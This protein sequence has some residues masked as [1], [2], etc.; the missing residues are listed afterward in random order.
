ML[1][2]IRIASF[3]LLV[4]S[5]FTVAHASPASRRE[6][7]NAERLARG[8]TPARPRRL[9]NGSRTNVARSAPSNLPGVVY[10]GK[11]GV[12][13]SGTSPLRKRIDTLGY[14]GA[15]GVVATTAQ[16]WSYQ[17]TQPVSG[18][19]PL[20]LNSPST[21]YRLSGVAIRS[22]PQVTLGPGN[23]VYLELQ[24]TRAHTAAGSATSV[25][26]Y[27]T[28]AIGY[29]QTSIFR[30]DLTGKVTY[31]WVN[32]DGS[33]PTQYLFYY[34]GALYITGDPAALQQQLGTTALTPVDLY[35]DVP[36]AV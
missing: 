31:S 12:V 36:D 17:Y 14:L 35:F 4:L 23:T 5:I 30:I 1:S 3:A 25:Y 9:Y 13:P 8:L 11:V 26:V 15:Y 16:A 32:P 33:V 2:L 7:T 6:A 27:D 19:A 24:N 28:Y 18:S 20:E 10:T 22:G 34:N 21:P 29:A